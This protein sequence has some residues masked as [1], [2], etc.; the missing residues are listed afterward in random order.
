MLR[1]REKVFVYMGGAAVALILLFTFV[2]VPGVAKVRS[3]SRAYSQAG[4][5]LAD[6]RNMRPELER[7]DRE[8][9]QK[10]GRVTA[11]SNASESPLARLTASLQEA[12]FPQAAFS[13]K[14]GG[15]KDG[16]FQRE[17]TFDLKIENLTYLEALRLVTRLENGPLPVVIRSAQLKSRYDDSK[18]LDTT[19]RIG[20][21]H[22]LSR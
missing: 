13:L 8:V 20:F 4:K 5:D 9:R 14:S 17:E 19:F 21:L 16:E 6:L 12:G 11:A 15:V 7:I 1:S 3:L 2:V 22:P 18:Y 10:S